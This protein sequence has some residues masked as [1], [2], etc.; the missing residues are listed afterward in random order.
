MIVNCTKI[1]S[2]HSYTILCTVLWR[3]A[4]LFHTK[5]DLGVICVISDFFF[6]S[7]Q[8]ISDLAEQLSAKTISDVRT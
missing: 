3:C 4:V 6:T 7:P 1:Y 5:E 8:Y 2:V